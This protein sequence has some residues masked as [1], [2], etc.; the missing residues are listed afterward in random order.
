M[1]K[2]DPDP[3]PDPTPHF[4]SPIHCLFFKKKFVWITILSFSFPLSR[5]SI[6]TFWAPNLSCAVICTTAN[7]WFA[8][9]KHSL[10]PLHACLPLPLRTLLKLWPLLGWPYPAVVSWP[11]ASPH[12]LFSHFRQGIF[13][14]VSAIRISLT[15]I[16][17]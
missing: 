3:L 16:K 8:C 5:M 17:I 2:G 10:R 7:T 12:T 9:I 14:G 13:L 6:S 4:P 1:Y 15:I 11:S